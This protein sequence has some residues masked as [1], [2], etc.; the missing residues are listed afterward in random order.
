[1][2]VISKIFDKKIAV[3]HKK[4]KFWVQNSLKLFTDKKMTVFT[5]KKITVGDSTTVGDR[6]E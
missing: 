5:D 2:F 6:R 4:F 3:I 1:V